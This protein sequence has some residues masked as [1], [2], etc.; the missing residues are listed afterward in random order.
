MKDTKVAIITGASR[1]IGK[2][3]AIGLAEGGY[4][5]ILISRSKE[6]LANVKKEIDAI[7]KSRVELSS[8]IYPVDVTDYES[9]KEIIKQVIDK[10]NRIDVLV[11]N[12]GIWAKGSLDVSEK[13]L[14]KV[15]NTNLIAPFAVLKE[16]VPVMKEQK[17]GYIFNIASRAGKYGFA[18]SGTYVS[19]KFALVGLSESLY[20]ELSEYHVKVTSI[21]PSW[22]NTDMAEEAG[23]AIS[24][25]E[26][27]QPEDITE[28]IRYLLKLSPAT[29][30]KDV[31]IECRL[32]I[33]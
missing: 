2:S 31:T 7:L 6:K 26:M 16:V 18:G 28:T 21:S 22:V 4:K 3:V 17:S 29:Y 9:S 27:I 23:S 30:I 32:R 8:E 5:T 11:N 13:E 25:E 24:K 12:A 33:K 1:G 19:S 20:R 15:L 14:S 10:Y